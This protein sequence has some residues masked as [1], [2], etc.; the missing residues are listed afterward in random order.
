VLQ[1]HQGDSQQQH[2]QQK[3]EKEEEGVDGLLPAFV[4]VLLPWLSHHNNSIR[5]FAQLVFWVI[6]EK[7]PLPDTS[8]GNAA[9]A[10]GSLAV[11]ANPPS[12]PTLAEEDNYSSSSMWLS[13]F[14]ARGVALLSQMQQYMLEN[15]DVSRMRRAMGPG[16]RSWQAEGCNSPRRVFYAGVQL[17]GKI[18]V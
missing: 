2:Q 9:A 7:H 15:V 11:V 8:P 3:Q 14:G 17:A 10:G 12:P 6:I 16:L 5:T 1:L 18:G 13:Y 4:Q